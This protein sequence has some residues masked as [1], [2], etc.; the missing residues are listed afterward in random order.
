MRSIRRR[1]GWCRGSESSETANMPMQATRKVSKVRWRSK[2]DHFTN[3]RWQAIEPRGEITMDL[4]TIGYEGTDFGGVLA[5]LQRHSVD[6]LVDVR[7]V[8]LSRKPGFSKKA[9]SGRLEENG[10]D[11]IHLGILGDPKPGR[12]AARSG[13]LSDFRRIYREHL[14]RAD[15]QE[16]CE[17]LVAWS[18]ARVCCLLCFERD[19]AV[20]HRSIIADSLAI[21]GLTVSHLYAERATRHGSSSSTRRNTGEGATTAQQALR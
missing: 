20:C 2:A 15:P 14:S 5:A 17:G 7:A 8:P 10:I 13:R 9:L 18:Q 3:L 21:R 4:Y 19:P 1:G 12:E 16:A 11:Y 6:V